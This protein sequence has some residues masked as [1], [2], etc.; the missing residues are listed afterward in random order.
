MSLIPKG[1]LVLVTGANGFLGSHVVDQALAAGFNVRGTVRSEGRGGWTK[2][3]F[4]KKYGAGRYE[5]VVV[6]NM[7]VKGA[8][9]EAVKGEPS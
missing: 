7:A 6:P 8:F 5:L 9:D 4:S 2:E 1:S 3:Y